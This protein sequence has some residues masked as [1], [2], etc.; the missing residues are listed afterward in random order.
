MLRFDSHLPR[1]GRTHPSTNI[2]TSQ[3]T[4]VRIG[5]KKCQPKTSQPG[6]WNSREASNLPR[7]ER[8]DLLSLMNPSTVILWAGAD[9]DG[10]FIPWVRIL[11]QAGNHDWVLLFDSPA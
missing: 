10:R 6:A 7:A 8:E 1:S 5:S 2:N 9:R 11:L 4:L 3:G